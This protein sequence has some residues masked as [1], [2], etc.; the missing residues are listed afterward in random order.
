MRRL[1]SKLK[2][3]SQQELLKL[4]STETCTDDADVDAEHSSSSMETSSSE[5]T[6]C[7]RPAKKF[8]REKSSSFQK[9]EWQAQYEAES[10]VVAD[11]FDSLAEDERETARYGLFGFW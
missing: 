5:P 4:P 3:R 1:S 2:K 10:T 8:A 7:A 11:N 9:G 6:V